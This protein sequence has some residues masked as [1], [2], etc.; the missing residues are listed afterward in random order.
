MR[1]PG[2]E[3]GSIQL[4]DLERRTLERREHDG[5]ERAE[6]RLHRLHQPSGRRADRRGDLDPAIGQRLDDIHLGHDVRSTTLRVVGETEEV[7]FPGSAEAVH[8]VGAGTEEARAPG[9]VRPPAQDRLRHRRTT[10]GVDG[11]IYAEHG[12]QSHHEPSVSH[13]RPAVGQRAGRPSAHHS[14]QPAE[15][16]W[17]R[18]AVGRGARLQERG[19]VL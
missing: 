1:S 2:T 12:A 4:L 3:P 16:P 9:I 6:C 7:R 10:L 11:R 15:W 13:T 19:P 5:V 18:A 14:A 17:G 8:E